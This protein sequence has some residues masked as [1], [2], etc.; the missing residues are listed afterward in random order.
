MGQQRVAA[1]DHMGDGV[2]LMLPQGDLR[3]HPHKAEMAAVV[4]PWAD[5]VEGV[6][7]N[8]AQ[9]LPPVNVLPKPI[10]K[11]GL[12]QFLPVLRN[13][14]FLHI[15]YRPLLAV[16]HNG[17]EHLDYPLIQ[18]LLQNVIC[19]NAFGAVGG[20]GFDVAAVHALVA[21]VPFAA[22]FGANDPHFLPGIYAGAE[23]LEHKLL[24]NLGGHP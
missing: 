20:D 6:V 8:T 9:P 24:I 23:Q 3:V 2:H 16:L 21:D 5:G 4:L 12:D 1:V 19:R 7:I 14:G 22:V 17:V 15:Q 18:R 11:F 10:G 13:G